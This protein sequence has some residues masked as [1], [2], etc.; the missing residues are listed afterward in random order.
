MTKLGSTFLK[1]YLLT[2][3]AFY[4]N[5][6]S[7][8]LEQADFSLETYLQRIAAELERESSQ[9]QAYLSRERVNQ[10]FVSLANNSIQ[11]TL[12]ALNEKDLVIK[13]LEQK[14]TNCNCPEVNHE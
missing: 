4:A 12:Q 8:H 11:I 5:Y 3:Q 9:I 13:N 2:K 10:S 1:A 6:Q 7:E 14:L